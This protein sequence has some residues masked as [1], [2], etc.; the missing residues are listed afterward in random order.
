MALFQTKK[1]QSF[2]VF[3]IVLVATLWVFQDSF[4][5]FLVFQKITE[6]S[7]TTS[8]EVKETAYKEKIDNFFLKE[9]SK[10]L[11]LLHTINARTYYSFE[12]SPIEL[13]EVKVKTFN[14]AQEEGLLL[15]S[16]RAEILKSG[17]ISFNGEVEIQTITGISHKL[18]T[19]SLIVLSDDGLIKSNKQVT[20]LGEAS[21]IISEGLEMSIDS[22][23]MHLSGNV[24]IYEDS[25]VVIDTKNL[26]VDHKLGKKIYRSN[27]VTVYRSKDAIVTSESGVDDLISHG[28][29][30]IKNGSDYLSHIPL[31]KYMA[32]KDATIIISTGM[33][34]QEEIDDAVNAILSIQSD[35]SKLIILHCTSSYPTSPKNVNLRKIKVLQDRYQVAVG[36]SDHTEGWEAAVQAVTLG[37]QVI[38]KHFT[39]DKNLPGPDHWFSSDFREFKELVKQIR[40]AESR[41]GMSALEPANSELQVRDKW[42]LGLV[43]DKNII[44]GSNITTKDIA[45]R[46]PATG[47][48]PKELDFVIGLKAVRNCKKGESVLKRDYTIQ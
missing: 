36:F 48:R 11:V 14:E 13:Y 15:I 41:M 33:A 32:S 18:T 23:T 1:I 10:E 26:Y 39:F 45:I 8:E 30:Y 38:E 42:R 3:I 4:L 40:L 21:R 46:K 31:L 22:D 37:A 47:L 25:G 12:N 19:E 43:W 16:N 9:Y 17:E 35:K 29:K 6:Q 7:D 5:K 2:I 28:V 27:E 44:A 34:Y 20:Y 24:K